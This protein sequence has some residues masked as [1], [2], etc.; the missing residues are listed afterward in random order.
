MF[1]SGVVLIRKTVEG[2]ETPFTVPEVF[3]AFEA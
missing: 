3:E 2:T 1:N